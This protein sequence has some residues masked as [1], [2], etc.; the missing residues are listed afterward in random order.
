MRIN[1]VQS[2]FGR[3]TVLRVAPMIGLV[4]SLS[5]IGF[6]Q[7]DKREPRKS[8]GLRTVTRLIWQDNQEQALQCGDVVRDGAEWRIQKQSIPGLPTLDR[9]KQ[10]MVQMESVR[11]VVVV[12]VRDNDNGAFQSGWIALNPGVEEEEHGNHSHWHFDKSP[13]VV[14]SQLDIHQGNPAHVYEYQGDIYLANDKK[15]GFTILSPST[16]L[17]SQSSTGSR[18]ISAGGSHITL[19]AVDN[20]V[21]YATWADRDG[22]NQGRVDVI[23]LASSGATNG[24]SLR[25]PSGGLHG[26]T[27]NSGKVFFAPSD[28]ICWVQ[29]DLNLSRKPS[30]D[31]IHHLS[32]GE[33]AATGKPLRTGAFA[34]HERSVLFTTGAA[35]A[36]SLCILD[37]SLAKPIVTKLSIPVEIGLSLTTPKTVS[38]GPQGKQYACLFADRR[39]SEL[40]ESLHIV[41][42]DPNGDGNYSDAKLAKS[43][44][45]GASK[46]EGHNGHHE[47][48]F[49]PQRKLAMLSN[50]GDGSIWVL[51]LSELEV[52]AKISLSGTPT[53]LV[54]V[55]G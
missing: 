51:S 47:I 30:D 40:A 45:V 43:I 36:S 28:G 33:D 12:G 10:S 20:Q 52:Q 21:C 25:L 14:A 49:V 31:Q 13:S 27:A 50:P 53:R 46:I 7:E 34:N 42:L 15:N 5:F 3:T 2:R 38:F 8:N 32:L 18:F 48:C 23:S 29:A 4:C 44:A 55:G 11:G 19:A 41:D 1:V 16:L 24:Y 6:S 35:E 9:D 39:G 26:A 22:D 17:K 37:A 54:A